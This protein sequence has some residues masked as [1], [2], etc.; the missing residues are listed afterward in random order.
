LK[1]SVHLLT[2]IVALAAAYVVI[3]RLFIA[4]VPLASFSMLIWVPSGISLAAIL[5]LGWRV[6][7]GITIGV[8]LSV[9]AAGHSPA[10]ALWLGVIDTLEALV[11]YYLLVRQLAIHTALDRVR[12][13]AALVAVAC[14]LTLVSSAVAVAGLYVGSSMSGDRSLML[15]S[16]WWW[17]HLAADLIIAPVVLT[18]FTHSVRDRT[19]LRLIEPLALAIT[20]TVASLIVFDRSFTDLLPGSR[21]P[22]YL[23]PVLVWA[24]VRFTPRGASLAASAVGVFATLGTEFRTGPFVDVTDFQSFVSISSVM[25]L[26]LAALA[27]ERMQAIRRKTA[28]QRGALDAII[29]IDEGGHVIDLNPAAEQLFGYREADVIGKELAE[30]IIPPSLRDSHR[31]GLS[32]YHAD[33]DSSVVGRRVRFPAVRADGSEFPAEISVTRVAVDG[34]YVFTGFV[35]DVTAEHLADQARQLAQDELARNVRERTV[36]LVDAYERLARKQALLRDAQEL[37]HLG[38]FEL[39]VP[40]HRA[41]WSEE[42]QRIY[43]LDP[44]TGEAGYN[45]LFAAVHPDDRRTVR[46]IIE[47]AAVDLEPFSFE[48]RIIRTDG[49]LRL[50]QSTGR[51]G[52]GGPRPAAGINRRSQD[53]TERKQAEK[54]RDWLSELVESSEDAIVGLAVDGTIESWNATAAKIFGYSAEEAIGQSGTILVSPTER[55]ELVDTIE[56]VRRGHR[57]AHYE[58]VHQRSDGTRFDASVTT[59]AIVDHQGRVIGISKVI[60]DV[61]EQKAFEMRL[62]SSLREKE[63]LLREIYHRVKN[64]LQVISSLLNLQVAAEPSSA[65]RHGLLES[66]SRIQSMALV[67]QLLYQSKDLAR[68]DFGEYLKN[69]CARLVQTY[70]VGRERIAIEVVAASILVDID[71]AIPCGLIVN[72][73][74]TNALNHAFPD[75]RRGHI[76][77]TLEL[78][79][80]TLRLAV[81]DDGIGLPPQ[82]KIENANTFGLQ[83]ARTLTQ[84]LAG[85]L[86]IV[87]DNGTTFVVIVPAA[88]C[89][90]ANAA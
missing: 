78:A 80:D 8:F 4:S 90:R 11:A 24:G 50:L 37:A 47:G 49:S 84:Q 30:L 42:L 69:L 54:A 87:R 5:L 23:M 16:R 48:Q 13:V 43:G 19:P 7:P 86:E 21:E 2:Q 60:R 83:I 82:I 34:H 15:W 68:V 75:G 18:W 51:G 31:H 3:A 77:V 10:A 36:E 88:S 38:S 17:G 61:S 29:T 56:S 70:H 45:A 40:N 55:R 44:A 73:L 14:L 39:D 52:G 59:S 9:V 72:E 64:N 26:L 22:Y 62:R 58:M 67:H 81:R 33:S 28:I 63:I 25:T 12:D 66:Q 85:R 1:R 89:A 53:I 35:R 71:R 20:L 74:V 32:A 46:G 27:F 6:W 79:G 57:L 41:E 65:A 76:W